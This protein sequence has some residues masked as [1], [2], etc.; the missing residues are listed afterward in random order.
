MGGFSVDSVSKGAVCLPVDVNIQER[1]V[2]LIFYFHGELYG[3]V[4][5]I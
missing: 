5:P 2:S 3:V 1:E 4:D